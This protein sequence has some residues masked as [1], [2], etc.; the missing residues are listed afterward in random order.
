MRISR[1]GNRARLTGFTLIEA[2][3]SVMLLALLAALVLPSFQSAYEQVT[4]RDS[5]RSF[6]ATLRFMRAKAIGT[7]K[8]QSVMLHFRENRYETKHN[9]KLTELPNSIKLRPEQNIAAADDNSLGIVFYP[10]GGSSGGQVFFYAGTK[11][12][13]VSVS[14]ITGRVNVK[15]V[16]PIHSDAS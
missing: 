15:S 10:S 13:L 5:V 4:L 14:P 8:A 7:N 2:L 1:V 11:Y 3:L 9:A 16:A 12:Y 6:T